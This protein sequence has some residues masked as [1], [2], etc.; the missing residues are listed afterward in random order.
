MTRRIKSHLICFPLLPMLAWNS[1]PT[2]LCAFEVEEFSTRLHSS[3]RFS[4][5]S[6]DIV[7]HVNKIRKYDGN[8]SSQMLLLTKRMC[9]NNASFSWP[10]NT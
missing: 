1:A 7:T 2:V 10:P 5:Q 9:S 6:R 4:G 8:L 3:N